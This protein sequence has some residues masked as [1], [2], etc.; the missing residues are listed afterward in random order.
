[1][2]N[3]V[4]AF[5]FL[6]KKFYCVSGST[7]ETRTCP[8]S[9]PPFSPASGTPVRPFS[10]YIALEQYTN[11][12]P[13]LHCFSLQLFSVFVR[14]RRLFPSYICTVISKPIYIPIPQPSYTCTTR[15]RMSPFCA[16]CLLHVLVSD[17]MLFCVAV[18]RQEARRRAWMPLILINTLLYYPKPPNQIL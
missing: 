2:L 1:V 4:S 18:I 14:V 17:L 11:V 7:G 12:F 10:V 13:R 9:P 5:H 6:L 3:L 16:C 8:S 15:T